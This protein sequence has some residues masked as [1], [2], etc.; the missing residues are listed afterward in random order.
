MIK[1]RN[2]DGT[3]TTDP[4]EILNMQGTFYSDLYTSKG[5]KSNKSFSR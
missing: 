1:L 2:D 3:I 4:D 5:K